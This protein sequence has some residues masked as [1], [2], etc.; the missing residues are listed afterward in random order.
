MVTLG[1]EARREI[2]GAIRNAEKM[3]SGEIR[4][5]VKSRCK[6]DVFEEAKKVFLRLGMHRTEERNGVLIFVAL[7]SRQFAILGDRG[8]HER[9]GESFWNKMRDLMTAHFSKGQIQ[10]G[11]VAGVAG[12]G[13][14][15]NKHFP[16]H[17]DDRNELPD[18]VTGV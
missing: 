9:V 14:E 18:R 7:D 4:V 1:K 8:V 5:H 2:V 12:A 16:K 17:A 3:T 10:A 15:L 13:T 6:Q 11:I